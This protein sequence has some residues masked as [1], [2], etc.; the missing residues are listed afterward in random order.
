MNKSIFCAN[1]FKS[2]FL[3]NSFAFMVVIYYAVH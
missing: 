2:K 3:Y 1:S